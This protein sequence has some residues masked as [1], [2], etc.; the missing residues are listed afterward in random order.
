MRDDDK[1]PAG[2]TD[3]KKAGKKQAV[4][5]AFK[6]RLDDACNGKL[7]RTATGGHYK[8]STGEV[9]VIGDRFEK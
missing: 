3:L 2:I 1:L 8:D 4:T 5:R 9:R 6:K 7:K